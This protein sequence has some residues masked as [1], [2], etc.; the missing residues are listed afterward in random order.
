MRTNEVE[1]SYS[2]VVALY[3]GIVKVCPNISPQIQLDSY[4]V[5]PRLYWSCIA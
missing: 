3:I 2:T 1:I 4:F 5:T